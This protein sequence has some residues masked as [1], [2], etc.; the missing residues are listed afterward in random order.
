M[1]FEAVVLVG[2]PVAML[3][4]VRRFERSAPHPVEYWRL[5]LAG[6]LGTAG[7]FLLGG[8]Y[9]TDIVLEGIPIES[10]ASTLLLAAD[11]GALLGLVVGWQEVRIRR[12][13]RRAE[14]A[15]ARADLSAVLEG[16]LRRARQRYP[17]ARFEASV[18]QD[19]WIV[20][21]EATDV[22]FEHL[23]ENAV[24]HNDA[25]TPAV[26]V[27]A[28]DRGPTVV[29]T[30]ADNGPGIPDDRKTACFERGAHGRESLGEGLGLYLA[31][32][33]VTTIGGRIAIEDN[34]PGGT[35]A[36]VELRKPAPGGIA[37]TEG[38]GSTGGVS[39]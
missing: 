13:V 16:T 33:V 7:A 15:E 3:L 22:A 10:L 20:G 8:V 19:R 25:E 35:R 2:A 6:V 37:S 11:V 26:R 21:S 17:G 28:V 36:A 23:L 24:K 30:V 32:S 12:S 4:V 31:E 39:G 5:V 27:E 9:L 14:R 38:A 34:V 29:V 1:L 18:P